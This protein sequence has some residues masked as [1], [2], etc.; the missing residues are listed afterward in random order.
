MEQLQRTARWYLDRKGKITASEIYLLLSNHKEEVPL[1]EEEQRRFREEHP[2]AK[3]PESKKVDMPFSQQTYSYLE[4]KVAEIFMTDENFL[5]YVEES[6]YPTK[7][8]RWGIELESEA[9]TVYSAEM[10]AEVIETGFLPYE[11]FPMYAGGSPDGIK[12]T[13][14]GIIEIKCPF[15]PAI[16]LKHYL[17]HTPNDLKELNLQYY[18]QCQFNMLNTGTEF[19]DFISYD[20]RL[21]YETQMSILRIPADEEMQKELAVR[22]ELAIDYMVE[23]IDQINNNR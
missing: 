4:G 16:H 9:R 10:D 3:M 23:K 21:T 8:M 17:M 18:A 6:N 2:R 5:D 20:P 15:N 14:N 1:T 12:R 11:A 7:A 13:E 19:C 22:V